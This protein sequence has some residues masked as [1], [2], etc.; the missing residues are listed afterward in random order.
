M[1]FNN[2]YCCMLIRQRRN[3]A[4]QRM[5]IFVLVSM[6]LFTLF[7]LPLSANTDIE[8]TAVTEPILA[9]QV[10]PERCIALHRG[11]TCYLDVEFKWT[12]DVVDDYCLINTTT[13]ELLRCWKQQKQGQHIHEF[14]SS[15][16]NRFSLI[17]RAESIEVGA[18]KIEVAWVYNSTK[19]AKSGWRLF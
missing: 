10:T 8:T 19:R 13:N 18:T 16:S 3:L 11:Q 14:Q 15:Q 2:G 17:T 6:F 12:L 1:F 4:E 9:L 7:P 5:T